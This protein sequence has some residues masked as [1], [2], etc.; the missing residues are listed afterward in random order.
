VPLFNGKDTKGWRTHDKQP[1]DWHVEG[2]ALTCR[3]RQSHL[4]SE[5]GDFEDFHLKAEVRISPGGNSGLFFRSEFGLL[6][7]GGSGALPLG[8]EVEILPGYAGSLLDYVVPRPNPKMSMD[9]GVAPRGWFDLDVIADGD[10]V[11]VRVGGNT[12][13]DCRLPPG[14]RRRGHFALQHFTPGARVEFRNIEIK[15]LPPTAPP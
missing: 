11:Q 8:Y 2:G 7:W 5:R 10:R 12:T 13:V 9:V 3:G 14:H 15:E 6:K 4:F 1:G